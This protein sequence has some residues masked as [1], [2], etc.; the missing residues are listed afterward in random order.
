[1]D[2]LDQTRGDGLI[3]NT[4]FNFPKAVDKVTHKPLPHKSQTYNVCGELLQWMNSFLTDQ[5]LCV[6]VDQAL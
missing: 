4:I 3:S 5:S 1:M 6:G 2:S